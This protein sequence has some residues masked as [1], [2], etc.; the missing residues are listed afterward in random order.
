MRTR[1]TA[2]QLIRSALR[3]EESRGGIANGFAR[4]N[5]PRSSGSHDTRSA[6]KFRPDRSAIEA[7][8]VSIRV[9]A[10]GDGSRLRGFRAA[11]RPVWHS[12]ARRLFPW[13]SLGALVNCLWLSSNSRRLS[14]PF[15]ASLKSLAIA[16]S[17]CS[18][19]RCRDSRF[20]S[21][22]ADAEAGCCFIAREVACAESLSG[23]TRNS[24]SRRHAR[25]RSDTARRSIQALTHLRRRLRRA[26]PGLRHSGNCGKV[27]AAERAPKESTWTE[28]RRAI[29]AEVL[30]HWE[31]RLVR[32]I[33][34]AEH[35]G[36]VAA[37]GY[38]RAHHGESIAALHRPG[39]D[40]RPGAR[41][42]HVPSL[43]AHGQ[44]G[45]LRGVVTACSLARSFVRFGPL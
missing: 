42:D 1:S 4:L 44:A 12:I 23:T 37:Q 7:G 26:R 11:G 29:E 3:V 16:S 10:A 8:G 21:I 33:T 6:V 28:K 41:L 39:Y 34:R 17:R 24:N 20:A 18:T 38:D 36:P 22:R 31:H 14:A 27:Y 9:Y 30:P 32:G 5:R 45:P 13:R 15:L 19:R 35:S 2:R 25:R 43:C 40:V